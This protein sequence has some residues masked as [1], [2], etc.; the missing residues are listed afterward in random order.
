MAG[1]DAPSR[2]SSDQALSGA[3]AQFWAAGF[4][5][6]CQQPGAHPKFGEE[7]GDSSSSMDF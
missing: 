6:E 5:E 7:S 3:C 1:R 4:Y 2:H